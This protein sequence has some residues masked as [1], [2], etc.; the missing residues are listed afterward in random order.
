MHECPD[1][2]KKMMGRKQLPCGGFS[3]ATYYKTGMAGMFTIDVFHQTL[4]SN[5]FICF[6]QIILNFF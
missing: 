2:K 3:P 6:G 1:M 4:G 5:E